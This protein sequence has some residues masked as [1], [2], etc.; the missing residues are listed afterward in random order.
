M[1]VSGFLIHGRCARDLGPG[2]GALRA[3]KLGDVLEGDDETLDLIIVVEL[4]RDPHQERAVAVGRRNSSCSSMAGLFGAPRPRP[5]AALRSPAARRSPAGRSAARRSGFEKIERSKVGQGD[6]ALAIETD[7]TR[8]HAA[9]HRFGK[10]A[11]LIQLA[12]RLNQL[13]ALGAQLIGHAVEGALQVVDLVVFLGFRNAHA[14]VAVA[15]LV[16]GP[17]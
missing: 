17:R 11:A 9:D 16:G 4:G 8:G 13:I 7:H 1:G 2:G 12:V 6:Q 14:E 5:R 3:E 15:D 10:G